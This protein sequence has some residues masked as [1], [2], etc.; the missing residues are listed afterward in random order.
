MIQFNELR[1]S[2]DGKKLIVDASV[3]E[4]GYYD[5]VYIDAVIIDNQTTYVSGNPS[6]KPVFYYEVSNPNVTVTYPE[7]DGYVP[8][9]QGNSEDIN[10]KRVRIEL[11]SKILGE[12]ISTNL[13]FVYVIAKGT[14]SPNTPCGMDNQTTL[15]VVADL[16]PYYRSVMNSI[17]E[18]SNECEIP[19]TFIDNLLRFKALELSLKT[20]NYIQAIKYWNKF[21]V[22]IKSSNINTYCKCHG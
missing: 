20:G 8:S 2:P 16:Y 3:K 5:N 11:D 22:G 10:E 21:F 18:I 4:L 12:P 14:P 7:Y 9:R 17:K 6:S 13:F 15:G 1:I 19:K